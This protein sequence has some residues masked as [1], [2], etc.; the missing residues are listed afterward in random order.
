MDY[1]KFLG[2]STTEVL[3]Y[4]GGASVDAKTRRLRVTREV[5]PGWWSFTIEGRRA[6]PN[7]PADPPDMEGLPRVRGHL[8]GSWLFSGGD[9]PERV[10][11]LP[12]DEQEPL[13]LVAA[14]R[15]SGELLLF[16]GLEFEG[17]AEGEAREALDSRAPIADLKGVAASLRAAYGW[18]LV[19]RIATDRD[20]PVALSEAK[21][22][23]R[24]IAERG[25]DAANALL[26]ELAR[27]RREAVEAAAIRHAVQRARR[28]RE[29]V[30]GRIADALH[31][32]GAT[33]RRV[34]TFEDGT[35][36]VRWWF[37]DETFISVVDA[38]TLQVIDSGICLSGADR[39]T[40]LQSLASVI[41]EAIDT[42]QLCITRT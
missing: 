42:D 3:P 12:A 11:L 5:D 39:I 31:A 28:V 15:W 19:S 9:R 34:R 4:L 24:D 13:A 38:E 17:D 23:L 6:E 14:R 37:M 25:P 36:E 10:H 16:D 1:K 2:Q 18:A 8:V 32:A 33:L 41:R 22:A 40:N 30:G 7:A 27:R 21:R 29:T 20:I 35:V 26:D